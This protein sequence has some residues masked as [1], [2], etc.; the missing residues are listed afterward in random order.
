MENTDLRKS[1]ALKTRQLTNLVWRKRSEETPST[2]DVG[3]KRSTD[4]LGT[5]GDLPVSTVIDAQAW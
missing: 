2:E 4:W 1:S 5:D 3:A